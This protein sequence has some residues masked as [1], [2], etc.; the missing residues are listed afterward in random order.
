MSKID[1]V[2]RLLLVMVCIFTSFYLAERLNLEALWS[3]IP[4]PGRG[5][6][7]AVVYY[8]VVLDFGLAFALAA[9]SSWI[10]LQNAFTRGLKSF[11]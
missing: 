6:V 3:D 1:F 11:Y 2:F 4:Q 9:L 5:I 10:E 7:Q 8:Y